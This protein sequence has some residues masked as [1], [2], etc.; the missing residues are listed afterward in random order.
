M[1]KGFVIFR[2]SCTEDIKTHI[3]PVFNKY[4]LQ[5]PKLLD[6]VDWCKAA[7]IMKAKGHLTSEGLEQLK[8]IKKGMNKGRES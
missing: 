3:T 7:E 1:N 5:G 2:V 6:F 8:N 4:P